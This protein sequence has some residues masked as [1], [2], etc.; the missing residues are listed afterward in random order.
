MFKMTSVFERP[1]T[2]NDFF[3]DVHSNDTVIKELA[4]AYRSAD[5]FIDVTFLKE[6]L[7][8]TIFYQFETKDQFLAHLE[9]YKDMYLKRHQMI[10][11][12][13]DKTNHKYSFYETNE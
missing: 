11:E 7:T 6:Q 3:Y 1:D 13:C 8:Y 10:M 9:S 4:D 2:S 12:Y 5:G